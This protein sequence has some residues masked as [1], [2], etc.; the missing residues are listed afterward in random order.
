M[1]RGMKTTLENF[2]NGIKALIEGGEVKL[3]FMT[4]VDRLA[5]ESLPCSG[6]NN[7]VTLKD[8]YAC[9]VGFTKDEIEEYLSPHL[10]KFAKTEDMTPKDVT[11]KLLKGYGGY[12]FSDTHRKEVMNPVSVMACLANPKFDNYGTQQIHYK[13]C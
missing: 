1:L 3:S 5:F 6:P 10:E 9:M 11:E 7:V 8:E 2:F 12:V 13:L 4:G